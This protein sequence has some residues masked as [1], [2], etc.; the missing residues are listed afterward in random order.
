MIYLHL[1]WFPVMFTSHQR[2][3][4][5]NQNRNGHCSPRPLSP[6]HRGTNGTTMETHLTVKQKGTDGIHLMNSAP[7]FNS[8]LLSICGSPYLRDLRRI[9]PEILSTGPVSNKTCPHTPGC[10]LCLY[11]SPAMLLISS[12][13][14]W[15]IEYFYFSM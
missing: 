12:W 2:K 3:P 6:G 11:H 5:W 1:N 8:V 15:R 13:K 14:H 7:V 9:K 10:L 4:M